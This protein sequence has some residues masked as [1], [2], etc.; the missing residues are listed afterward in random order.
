MTRIGYA[1]IST[2]DQNM[3]RQLEQLNQ[4][5]KLFQETISGANKDRPQL[6]AM[7]A[8][9][10][11]GDI[12]VVTELE[13]LGRN[14]KELTEVMN[15]IQAKGAT[16]EVLNLPTLRGIED[17]NLRRLL[18]NLILEL[19]KYQAQAER[20]RIKERQRQGIAIAKTQGKYKGRKAIFSEDDSRL[21]HAFDL[22]LE[23][24]SDKDVAKLTGINERTFR[25]YREKHK[26]KR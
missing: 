4:V 16:L 10:R 18:N 19:Y 13:R 22:Y 12:V 20:E 3:A 25:R 24:L 14:N 9:I 17:D 5:D 23:G 21:L 7:L 11:E 26:I 15:D 8:Y 6:Q 1:R 2:S